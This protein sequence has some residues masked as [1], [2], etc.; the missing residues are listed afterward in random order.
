MT[1]PKDL[2]AGSPVKAKRTFGSDPP[3]KCVIGQAEIGEELKV[4]ISS[5]S[6]FGQ[7]IITL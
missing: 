6:I 5:A 7:F 1:L 4:D 3:L 2:A